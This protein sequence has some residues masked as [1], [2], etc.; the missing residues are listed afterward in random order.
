MRA[1]PSAQPGVG[2]YGGV[3]LQLLLSL[4]QKVSG[5]VMA[6]DAI[7]VGSGPGGATVARAGSGTRASDVTAT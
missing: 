4:N 6:Y 5:P 2:S 3:Q 7:I 1:L